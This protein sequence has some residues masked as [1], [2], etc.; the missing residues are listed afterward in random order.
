LGFNPAFVKAIH[1]LRKLL[2]TKRVV[3]FQQVTKGIK[4]SVLTKYQGALLKNNI[5]SYAFRYTVRIENQG[6]DVVQ[7]INRHWK[8]MESNRR[9]MFI[10]GAG[11][12][13]KKPVLKSGEV[14]T[15]QSNC[16]L[17][18]PIG[19]M[20]GFYT[21]VNFSSAQEFDVEIPTF[22]LAATFAMN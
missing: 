22:K 12:I 11:V 17:T 20:K 14:H 8:I 5:P 16:V 6:K 13:G 21:M 9:P 7:L 1:F 3:M 19:A 2:N 15:Y 18:S 4:I 10:D